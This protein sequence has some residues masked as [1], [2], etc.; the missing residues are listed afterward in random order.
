MDKFEIPFGDT[1]LRSVQAFGKHRYLKT[2]SLKITT[3]RRLSQK[4]SAYFFLPL[5]VKFQVIFLKIKNKFAL[6]LWFAPTLTT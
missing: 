5:L 2:P 3:R 4:W 6:I 1:T